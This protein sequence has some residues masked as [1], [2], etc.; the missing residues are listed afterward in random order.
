MKY[1]LDLFC[2]LKVVAAR[3]I[4]AYFPSHHFLATR[5]SELPSILNYEVQ[6]RP[7]QFG[8]QSHYLFS[9]SRFR[10]QFLFSLAF[11]ATVP[12]QLRCSE[13]P[14][15]LSYDVQ[16]CPSQF[17]VQSHYLF[18][19]SAFGAAISS[20]LRHSESFFIV[21]LSEPPSL[22]SLAL[23]ATVPSQLRCSESSFTVWCSEPLS[24]LSFGVQSHH[25]FLVMA[26]KAAISLQLN[27]QSRHIFSV[28]TFKAVFLSL[29]FRAMFSVQRSELHFQF[30]VQSHYL[31]SLAFKATILSRSSIHCHI[32][33][34]QSHIASIQ[35]CHFL[36]FQH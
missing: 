6:S 29:A 27:V 16:S 32:F 30:G 24:L 7:S 25:P 12:S 10:A 8:V 21:W 15:L 14:Y 17:G 2:R 20:Q 36:L 34:V 22:F 33:S 18:S 26:F 4:G 31:F 5:R 11:R 19:V 9:V 35:S 13:P 23:K 1:L 3:Y 28:M